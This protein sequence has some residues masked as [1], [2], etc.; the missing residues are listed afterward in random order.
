ME[1]IYS[2]KALLIL[3]GLVF[4]TIFHLVAFFSF[5]ERMYST[6][7]SIFTLKSQIAAQE[8]NIESLEVEIL[9]NQSRSNLQRFIKQDRFVK[10]SPKDIVLYHRSDFQNTQ[11][12]KVFS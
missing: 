10:V 3:V 1:D 11:E 6:N 2:N 12:Q 7:K 9:K 4:F 5:R 8:R